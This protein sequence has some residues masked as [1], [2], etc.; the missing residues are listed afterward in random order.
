MVLN[1]QLHSFAPSNSDARVHVVDLGS[2][3]GNCLV[4]VSVA[5]FSLL[6]VDLISPK[7][8]ALVNLIAR[9]DPLP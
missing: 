8:D 6:L 3:E 1:R 2:G 5:N 4:V 7:D 9:R